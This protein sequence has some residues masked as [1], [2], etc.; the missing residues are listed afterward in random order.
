MARRTWDAAQRADEALRARTAGANL[1]QHMMSLHA[2]PK[3]TA[4]DLSIACFHCAEVG[5]RGVDFRSLGLPVDQATGNYQKRVD[6][7]VT[8]FE[9]LCRLPTPVT[10]KGQVHRVVRAMPL[11]PL[12]EDFAREVRSN[13]AVVDVALTR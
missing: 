12:L 5:V 1:L 13:P 9:P 4:K 6:R 11:N 7:V 3:L 10:P 8:P 2:Q